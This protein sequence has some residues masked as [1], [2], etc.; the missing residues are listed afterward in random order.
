MTR[1]KTMGFMVLIMLM[2]LAAN[3]ALAASRVS[4]DGRTAV[5]ALTSSEYQQA[6]TIPGAKAVATGS[7]ISILRST[8]WDYRTYYDSNPRELLWLSFEDR[9]ALDI[10]VHAWAR[11]LHIDN[12]GDIGFNSWLVTD[13]TRVID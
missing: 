5:V 1:R 7:V 8:R 6:L 10:N 3:N 2:V 13:P 11:V 12:D 4:Y 9:I